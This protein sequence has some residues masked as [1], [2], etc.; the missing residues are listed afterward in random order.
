VGASGRVTVGIAPAVSGVSHNTFRDFNVSAAGVDLNNA[1]VGA[2]NIVAQVTGTNPS[3]LAGPLAVLGPRANVIIANSN[4]VSVNGLSVSGMGNLALTTGQVSFNDFT[5]A[6]GQTQ[7]NVVLTTGQGAIDI[8]PAGLTGTLL[9]LELIARQIRVGGAVTNLYGDSNAKVRLVAGNSRAEIDSSVSPTD[10]LTPWVTYTAQRNSPG[11]G[12]AI[13]I[14]AAGSLMAGRIELLVTDQ[15]AGVRH[16]GSAL[17]TAGDFVVTGSGDLQLASGTIQAKRDVLIDSGGATGQGQVSA[18]RHIQIASDKVALTQSTLTAGTNEPGNIV[19]GSNGQV[20]STPVSLTDSTLTASGG[21]GMYDAGP[22]VVLTGTQATA[23]GNVI[24]NT[25]SLSMAGDAIQRAA[26]QSTG[27]M[28]SIATGDA[29]LTSADIDGVAGTSIQ[30]H[31]LTLQ[32][33][34]L[35]SSGA[36]VAIDASG[37]YAQHDSSVLAATDARLHA[38]S[39]AIDSTN[40]QSVVVA[41]N[42]GVLIQSDTDVSN[43]GGLIQGQ[44]RIAGEPLSTG[45]V[46]VRAAGNVTN[47]S[48]PTY[49]GI[50]FGAGDDVEVTAGGNIVNRY[51]RIFSNEYLRL[52]A[53]GDVT[54]EVT[55][56]DGVGSGQVQTWSSSG[57]RWFVLTKRSAGFDVDYGQVD[58]PDQ[59]AY[60]LSDKGTTISGRNVTNY[61]GEIYANNGAIRITAT[62][63][64]RTEGVA[65]GSAHY[66][67][68][69]LIVC[70]TS[71]SSTTGVTGGLL[72]AGT[73]I[74]IQ[75][76][77]Q[78]INAGGRVLAIGNLNVTAPVIY[79]TGITGYTAIARDRGFKAFFG[80][81]W[82]R[83]YAQ[84]VGGSW[85]ASGHTQING[86][87]VT[88]GGS[89]DG[90]VSITGQSTVTRPRQR[91]PVTIENHLGLTSWLWH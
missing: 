36:A 11:Q 19:I 10:N 90:A 55:H 37:A 29:S 48:T 43:T 72:S 86:D 9:N 76:G 1:S 84:D 74:D 66:E 64:F 3:V 62:D 77:Q 79:A 58:R 23:A 42:G 82:A 6:N 57:Q 34:N 18:G 40:T 53:N 63:T 27:G 22:G 5:T 14:T 8:G 12:I 68:S 7:R 80:D 31:N 87:T 85:M 69:C 41:K 59:I 2:R 35:K 60:L 91:D 46:T 54:N 67:R 51:A 89:F 38:A 56:Q 49:L 32:D 15:G 28:V 61:G 75:A 21:I 71:A 45:A 30:A 39:V 33:A 16:A 20:H 4:G 25:A 13:D 73:D 78:A 52:Q 70:R 44:T 50:L 47:L 24:V 65:T 81:T 26:L 83:L 88:D 17:A